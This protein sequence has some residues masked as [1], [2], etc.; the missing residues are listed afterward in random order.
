MIKNIITIALFCCT[1]SSLYAQQTAEERSAQESREVFKKPLETVLKDI[2]KQYHVTLEFE[3][4]V[5][6]GKVVN[7]A[8]WRLRTD[9]SATLDNVLKPLDL[10]WKEKNKD[11]YE[12]TSFEY[13]RKEFSEGS[14]RLEE[15]LK[16]YPDVKAWEARKQEVKSCMLKAMGI[17]LSAKRNALNPVYRNKRKMDGYTAENVAFESIPGYFVCGTLYRPI[18][19][20]QHPVILSPHGHFYNKVDKFIQDE[21]GRYRP[22][23]QYRCGTLARMGA[24]V[25]DYDMYSYGE[26]VQQ[27]GSYNFHKTG[28]A[29]AIQ[30]WNSIRALD[31]LLSLPDADVK[32]VGVTGAS[33]GGTQTFLIAALDNRITASCPVVMVSSSFY[34]GC[35]CESGLPIHTCGRTNNAEIA[36]MA[37]PR[38]QLVI[39]D[40]NDWTQTVPTIEFPYL[41]KVYGLYNAQE[42]VVNTHL[43]DDHHDYGF[44]K[45]VPMYHFFAKEFGLNIKAVSDKN[46]AIDES[47]IT[48]ENSETQHVFNNNF[49]MPAYALKSH[50]SI[51]LAFEKLQK[52]A[53][54]PW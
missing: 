25:F 53:V 41:K 31:F 2:E 34:G 19:G 49:P 26:S 10:V 21:R 50:E 43:P 22:D 32:R 1:A 23:M 39:S 52:G 13:F 42:K 15:L 47:K 45:R 12:I 46:G 18:S 5:V 30:T 14:K 40:G 20:G 17:N 36:A 38:P 8:D 37:A 33:G 48:I 11:T 9:L 29:L 6:K 16:L 24:I 51:V 28:F 7:Y 44:T 54:A 27:S 3:P 4:K 35:N